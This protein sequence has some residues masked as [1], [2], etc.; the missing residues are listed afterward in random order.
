M[1]FTSEYEIFSDLTFSL[2]PTGRQVT[3]KIREVIAS[4]VGHNSIGI[5]YTVETPDGTQFSVEEISLQG[6]IKK[7]PID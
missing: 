4:E 5:F 2:F 1:K 6:E 7:D 3:G